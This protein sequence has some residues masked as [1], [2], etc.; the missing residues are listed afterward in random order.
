[1]WKSLSL[2][3]A[4]VITGAAA[5]TLVITSSVCRVPSAVIAFAVD[6]EPVATVTLE[7]VTLE[8]SIAVP[9]VTLDA[10]TSSAVTL[11]ASTSTAVTLDAFTSLAVTLEAI[12]SLAETLEASI[13]APRVT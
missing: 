4:R 8:A 12:T 3:L 13:A 6:L 2:P 7:V 1:V 11:E 5:L 10:D 9:K